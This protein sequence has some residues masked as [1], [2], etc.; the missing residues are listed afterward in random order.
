MRHWAAE[1]M[2]ARQPHCIQLLLNILGAAWTK[3]WILIVQLTHLLIIKK[4]RK[5]YTD[6]HTSGSIQQVNLSS[7]DSLLLT[8]GSRGM[9]PRGT[10]PVNYAN[11]ISPP[12]NQRLPN[13][14]LLL[15][16]LIAGSSIFSDA[17]RPVNM[18]TSSRLIHLAEGLHSSACQLNNINSPVASG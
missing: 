4:K 12:N 14:N 7:L 3:Q 6:K 16:K 11:S 2:G 17:A 15:S 18:L 9:W 5:F 1:W 8:Q 13:N 10:F